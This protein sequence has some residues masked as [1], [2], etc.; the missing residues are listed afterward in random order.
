ML[1]QISFGVDALLTE[2][3]LKFLIILVTADMIFHIQHL[4]VSVGAVNTLQLLV[5]TH[6]LS[7]KDLSNVILL[8]DLV[9]H[10][11]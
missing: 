7:V 1:N 11:R 8:V 10:G 9:V 5:F 6:C 2:L 4:I 3:A